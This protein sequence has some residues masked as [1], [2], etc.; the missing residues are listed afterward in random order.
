M[1]RALLCLPLLAFAPLVCFLGEYLDGLGI[2][3]AG[4]GFLPS[5]AGMFLLP[6][7]VA[8][9]ISS[10]PRTKMLNRALLFATALV[11]Q[12]V[13][14]FTVVPPGAKSQ[15]MGIAHRMRREFRID[16]LRECAAQ[17]R[18]KFNDATLK[19]TPRDKNDNF[20]VAQ[21]AVVVSDIEL[22]E[23]LRGRFQRVFIQKS[24]Q[25]GDEQVVFA[26]EKTKG[27]ICDSRKNVHEFFVWSMA[28]GVQAYR[29]QRM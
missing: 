14:M 19:V 27:I 4:F 11:L 20:I 8:V 3:P 16:E 1:R 23:S 5:I 22:P 24:A 26:V 25:T 6:W 13:L 17:I 2:L 28:D 10:I 12:G 7:I 29:Y 15:M 9:V 18:Q 21:D